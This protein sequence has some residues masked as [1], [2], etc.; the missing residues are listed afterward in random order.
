[1]RRIIAF[2]I[3]VGL[4]GIGLYAGY[5]AL[6]SEE[7]PNKSSLQLITRAGADSTQVSEYLKQYKPA[8]EQP[9]KVPIR[10]SEI[11]AAIVALTVAGS[12]IGFTRFKKEVYS[13]FTSID[14][15]LNA[16]ADQKNRDNVD[17]R[18][19]KIE[20]DAAAFVDDEKVKGLIEGMGSRSRLF[21]RDVMEMD[22]TE[23]CLEKAIL[24]M[25]ARAQDSKHQIKDL[26][27]TNYFEG[28]INEI[29]SA[30]LKQLKIDL[31]RLVEDKMHN[32]KY[33]RFGE[34]I[35]RFQRNYMKEVIKL[36]HEYKPEQ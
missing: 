4:I 21:C 5:V 31:T 28:R 7:N 8:P 10:W 33:E 19:V 35:C 9:E 27:F 22:F 14:E 24:K 17:A 15:L 3:I 29:R 11:T 16:V 25:N 36:H 34:I 13:R 32:S 18:L 12:G 2:S 30:Q 1:M 20:Q 26:G 6:K 23:D